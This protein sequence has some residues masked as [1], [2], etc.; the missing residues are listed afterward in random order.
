MKK[1]LSL[2]LAILMFASLVFSVPFT[3]GA[4]KTELAKTS[5][6]SGD[7]TYTVLPD[8]T[9]EITGYTGSETIL[10]TPST[11]D[12][13]KVTSIGTEAFYF[14]DELIEVT[15]P[16]GVIS[17]GESAFC[18]CYS[19]EKI[20]L[21][22]TVTSIGIAAFGWCRH[23]KEITIPAGVTI[24][25]DS[26]FVDCQKLE[27][28]TLSEG[29]TSI[30]FSS[31]D[32]CMNLKEITIP[33]SVTFIDG[34][35]F[36][37]CTSLTEITIPKNVA[38]IS[39]D[40]FADCTNLE[41]IYV[42][43]NECDLEFSSIPSTATIYCAEGSTA[44]AYAESNGNLYT[45]LSCTGNHTEVAL[46]GYDAT[47]ENSGLTDGKKCSVCGEILLEQETIP[48]TG[49]SFGEWVVSKEPTFYKDGVKTKSCSVCGDSESE[50]IPM[51]SESHECDFTGKEIITKEPTC[52]EAGIKI[53]YCSNPEC[54]VYESSSV[55]AKGHTEVTDARV[56]PECENTGLTEGSHC[57]DCGKVF[58]EQ[59]VIS[60]TGH[61][62]VVDKGYDATFES[63]GRTDGSHCSV[64]NKILV[65]QE[66]IP[67]LPVNPADFTYTVLP[68]GTAEIIG[69]TG[70]E[71][72]LNIPSILDG[73]KVTSIG[74]NAFLWC[75]SLIEVTIPDGV[76]NI[77]DYAYKN[78]QSLEQV[79]IPESVT[80]IGQ[81]AFGYCYNLDGITLPENVTNIGSC[82]F[83]DCTTLKE[84]VIPAGIT[85]INYGTFNGCATLTKVALPE[86][87]TSIG[88]NAFTRCEFLS[89]IT[90][91]ESVTTIGRQVFEGC[92]SL[93][94]IT[95]PEN[96]TSIGYAAFYE[97]LSLET[98]YV[99]STDCD[100]EFSNIPWET[101]IYCYEGSTAHDY[102][103]SYGNPCV[104][105]DYIKTM[106]FIYEV[107][108][109]GTAE[110]TGYTGLET[111]LTIPSALEGYI[112]TSIGVDAFTSCYSLE[113][114]TIPDTVTNIGEGAFGWCYNLKE[115]TIPAGVTIIP[116]SAF[117]DCQKLEKVT[118]SE[119][120]TSI[121]FSSFD[122]CMNLKEITIPESVTFIDGFA[123]FG[124]TS[125]TEI[126]IPKNVACISFDAFADCTNLETI[127][128]YNN[129]CDLEF[130][131]IPST[132]T[133]YCYEGSTAQA[134]AESN[135]N[136]YI[137]LS[138]TGDHTEVA[139]KGY[140]ATCENSGLTDG[141]KCSVCGFVTV[142]Q[143]V[144]PAKGHSWDDGE[145]SVCGEVCE[146]TA[147]NGEC[148]TCGKKIDTISKVEGHSVSLGD[149]VAVN[150]YITIDD[151]I[152]DDEDAKI[153]FTLPG[154][155]EQTVYLKDTEATDAGYYVFSCEVNAL[156]MTET[157]YAQV[158]ATGYESEVYS[159]SVL[160]YAESLLKAVADGNTTYADAVPLVKAML[161]YG[162][163]AQLHFGYNTDNLAN[164]ILSDE[165]KVIVDVNL[166]DYMPEITG[167]E[168][169]VK[170]YGISL[171]LNSKTELNIY[172]TIDDEENI[173]EFFVDGESVTPVKVDN[174]YRI[175]I[176]DIPAQN[177][178]KVYV[179]TVGG[180]TAKYSPMSY[181]YMAMNTQSETVK[182]VIKALYAY[183]Q[184]ANV[185][186]EKQ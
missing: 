52:T 116:D 118:L 20:T 25:P 6:T 47:C 8:G 134:Y 99:Y 139:L 112:V 19:L 62:E 157:V 7:F 165:D 42:Y 27:K 43:N 18:E 109:D 79:S 175:K 50:R 76:I 85:S 155:V 180:L 74:D 122:Y 91:P 10:T 84:I 46:K 3:V 105:L 154:N 40:A 13:Y 21:P 103:Y 163:S 15:I 168:E 4:A 172:F 56:E 80:N 129:E 151:A 141:K 64:C 31:F 60:A 156:Q 161:N 150:Y 11:L 184:A 132:A 130:S 95:I 107:L 34:F 51:L 87:I 169:G 48:A 123:F 128:V 136:L 111:I 120:I 88:N 176:A 33:E 78:C 54:S 174:Y 104:L 45:L 63:E 114:I 162:A 22:D 110:I 14:C 65:A 77:G 29:I 159:Y 38:C 179:V 97:C 67:A 119:G 170:V 49:H 71:T 153:V 182:N 106:G 86:G 73:Y 101:T 75:D 61:T 69:Y 186:I 96:V 81:F 55:P 178:D 83:W 126:T 144:I 143:T 145:C 89:D 94:E 160:E 23:L 26:A 58:V 9:A 115:I 117:V 113:K 41:T 181:G 17:I 135:G 158:V 82:A 125:L 57:A 131:S 166:D 167:K 66:V 53:T 177:L 39:F 35:A 148:S 2:S 146:H 92:I 37:G 16:D 36:F 152:A 142:I 147:V 102:S 121:G 5:A 164:N 138:C 173:P 68:D 185:Y 90:I 137:L 133:I 127:Y 100:L 140:D 171:T 108:P 93:T 59:E 1:L 28:V 72:I 32:Y 12:G 98:M 30:G 44:Q 183:N 70:S 24:I 124:C 149:N